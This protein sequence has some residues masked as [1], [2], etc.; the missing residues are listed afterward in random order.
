MEHSSRPGPDCRIILKSN[1][2][3][4]ATTKGAE[5][6]SFVAHPAQ[7]TRLLRVA[8]TLALTTLAGCSGGQGNTPPPDALVCED[9]NPAPAGDRLA[10]AKRIWTLEAGGARTSVMQVVSDGDAIVVLGAFANGLE[11]QGHS[12]SGAGLF[13]AWVDANGT[14][15]RLDRIVNTDTASPDPFLAHSVEGAVLTPERL[16]VAIDFRDRVEIVGANATPTTLTAAGGA[17]AIASFDR[18]GTVHSTVVVQGEFERWL[19]RL[20]SREEGVLLTGSIGGFA[21]DGGVEVLDGSGFALTPSV[22]AFHPGHAVSL[23]LDEG[24]TA[25]GWMVDGTAGS[26][27][28]TPG[29][30]G[31]AGFIV[32]SF[33]G[34]A[35]MEPASRFG[36]QGPTLASISADDDPA[37]DVFV[38]WANEAGAQ[39]AQRIR[40]YGS[41]Q[42]VPSAVHEGDLVVAVTGASDIGFQEG[43]RAEV[44][45]EGQNAFARIDA[46]GKLKWASAAPPI[47][48]LQVDECGLWGVARAWSPWVAQPGELDEIR[49]EIGENDLPP[50]LRLDRCGRVLAARTI[51]DA[52]GLSALVPYRP[53]SWLGWGTRSAPDGVERFVLERIDW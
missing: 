8:L 23:Y 44:Q 25:D 32:G 20:S 16:W 6:G 42:L 52:P 53:G 49:I 43:T 51:T 46:S 10:A 19:T 30:I 34:D 48:T 22:G 36:P 39:W 29:L 37:F 4:P 41:H 15:G 28:Q 9:G 12:L 11:L 24:G 33:G 17:M 18:S 3:N 50:V 47:A 21:G 5:P 7:M 40:R 1:G 38:G 2:C 26:T 13:A 35:S 14:V 27:L 31:D 45:I